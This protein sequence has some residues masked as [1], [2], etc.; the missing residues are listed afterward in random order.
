MQEVIVMRYG[1][2]HHSELPT[3]SNHYIRGNDGSHRAKWKMNSLGH[4]SFLNVVI[5][6]IV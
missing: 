5:L 2:V 6:L 4:V 1:K 3:G